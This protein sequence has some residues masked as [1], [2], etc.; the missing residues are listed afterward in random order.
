MPALIKRYADL[1]SDE[2]KQQRQREVQ[3]RR[4]TSKATRLEKEPGRKSDR[5]GTGSE[6]NTD[7]TRTFCPKTRTVKRD[8]IAVS[9]LIALFSVL[10]LVAPA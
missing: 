8:P 2:E 3:Q 1:F 7:R 9:F 5:H 10:F 6:G 4:Q